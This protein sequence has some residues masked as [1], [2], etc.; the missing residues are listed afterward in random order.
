MND[1]GHKIL[2]P[3]IIIPLQI[4]P[5]NIAHCTLIIEN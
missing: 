1:D 3:Y 4:A 5:L 2:C